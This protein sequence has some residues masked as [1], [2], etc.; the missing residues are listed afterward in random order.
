LLLFFRSFSSLF[1]DFFIYIQLFLL[2]P[3]SL[4]TAHRVHRDTGIQFILRL[5]D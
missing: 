1:L 2:L 4:I 3:L 5:A